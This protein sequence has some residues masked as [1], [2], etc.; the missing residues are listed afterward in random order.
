MPKLTAH[1]RARR[2]PLLFSTSE[3][4][5]NA[6]REEIAKEIN[7]AQ[8]E[9]LSE[10]VGRQAEVA[11]AACNLGVE[12]AVAHLAEYVERAEKDAARAVGADGDTLRL[13]A[14]GVREARDQLQRK[15]ESKAIAPSSAESPSLASV[16]DSGKP[17]GGGASISLSPVPA[18]R[19]SP[20]LLDVAD[21]LSADLEWAVRI[22]CR[23]LE[24][25]TKSGD[26]C[27][28]GV[29]TVQV[30]KLRVA[31]ECHRRDYTKARF[32]CLQSQPVPT[33]GDV[34][35]LKAAAI[36]DICE[37]AFEVDKAMR[38]HGYDSLRFADV[39]HGW[40][41]THR[42]LGP[43]LKNDPA[44][45]EA[46]R[47]T[48]EA[49]DREAERIE[50]EQSTPATPS[51]FGE[52]LTKLAE[53]EEK[54]K[55][56]DE[57]A[58]V[59]IDM[60]EEGLFD[61]HMDTSQGF[62]I[63]G[64][65]SEDARDWLRRYEELRP[66]PPA[67]RAALG[68][69]ELPDD[70]DTFLA[71]IE[72]ADW[73][74]CCTGDCPHGDDAECAKDLIKHCKNLADSAK[75]IRAALGRSGEGATLQRS[76]TEQ[77][78][79]RASRLLPIAR[80]AYLSGWNASVGASGGEPRCA[81]SLLTA[82][83]IAG[84]TEI[85]RS[86]GYEEIAPA[87][88]AQVA[89][90]EKALAQHAEPGEREA[91]LEEAAKV[92]DELC[93]EYDEKHIGKWNSGDSDFGRKC[94]NRIRS[95]KSTPA[96]P[97]PTDGR[98]ETP[99]Y[100]VEFAGEFVPHPMKDGPHCTRCEKSTMDLLTM[101]NAKLCRACFEIEAHQVYIAPAQSASGETK[102]EVKPAPQPAPA[103]E[104]VEQTHEWLGESS[105][106]AYCKRCGRDYRDGYDAPC[107]DA[108]GGAS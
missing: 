14:S 105:S 100:A 85:L 51:S 67:I 43:L 20:T 1:D 28:T 10:H 60:R 82:G 45:L 42:R 94:A 71:E 62:T 103:H 19:G 56:A 24:E 36:A 39:R 57:Y 9:A 54:A 50:R 106:V 8:L 89:E 91:A 25:R 11:E 53:M 76:H 46:R 87:L 35:A 61:A 6:L 79:N 16:T 74:G 15:L 84:I 17:Q 81:V 44:Y 13:I 101:A 59:L 5:L 66:S 33:S 26:S 97:A 99:R 55:L 3:D 21:N 70:I 75:R 88:A 41:M 32:D 58:R 23:L 49:A 104:R 93:R 80:A 27:G 2:I 65:E 83:E 73:H 48:D 92:C 29:W 69:R 37:G 102:G 52:R 38:E 72:V 68:L 108:K 34:D 22:A 7:G 86:I 64:M 12:F 96:S 98:A 78:Y 47:A 4:K 107:R 18:E 77:D 30:D 40:L 90:L 95:L 63:V 31:A